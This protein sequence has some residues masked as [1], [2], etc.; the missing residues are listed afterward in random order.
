[1]FK[2]FIMTALETIKD[3]D[4]PIM[5]VSLI[6]IMVSGI[7]LVFISDK[8]KLIKQSPSKE[9]SKL[10]EKTINTINLDTDN[11]TKEQK[12]NLAIELITKKHKKYQ[13][14]AITAIV[15]S[16]IIT[17]FIL[18]Y[19]KYEPGKAEKTTKLNCPEPLTDSSPAE[20]LFEDKK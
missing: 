4:T 7:I 13:L 8:E 3:I 20:C 15:L 19:D 12:Y 6:V 11:L 1:M 14:I 5:L 10:I 18:I 9:R 16:I 2:D 17:A